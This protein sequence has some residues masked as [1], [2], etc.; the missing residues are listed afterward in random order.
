MLAESVQDVLLIHKDEM[1]FMKGALKGPD[2][3]TEKM[4]VEDLAALEALSEETILDE[5]IQRYKSGSTYTFVG[6]VLLSMN[7][8]TEMPDLP[9]G[10]S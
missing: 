9:R 10:V 4:H 6:D 3:K 2:N 7:P 1:K 8:N 5:L